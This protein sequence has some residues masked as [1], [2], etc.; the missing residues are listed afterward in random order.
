[1]RL[2]YACPRRPETSRSCAS[3][4]RRLLLSEQPVVGADVNQPSFFC[5]SASAEA[6]PKKSRRRVFGDRIDD[7][8]LSHD[9]KLIAIESA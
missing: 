1:M 9:G 6:L 3:F 5:D 4:C 8:K 7:P 2:T